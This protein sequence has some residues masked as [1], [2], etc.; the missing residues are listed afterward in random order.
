MKVILINPP[1]MAIG[2]RIPDDHLP[3]LGLLSIGGP[4]IDA[5]FAVEL[6]DADREDMPLD[7][8]VEEVARRDPAVVLLGHS[9]SSSAHATVVALC[10]AIKRRLPGVTIIYG[11]VHPTYHWDEISRGEPVHRHHRAR[12]R[13]ADGCRPDAGIE[14]PRRLELGARHRLP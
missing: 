7:R 2:S 10:T 11:G 5:G 6:V 12:R 3:P 13:R 4:L 9:G 14:G 1:H 8:I